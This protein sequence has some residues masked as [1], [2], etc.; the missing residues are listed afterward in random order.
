MLQIVT[1]SL[2]LLDFPI[3]RKSQTCHQLILS[4][5]CQEVEQIL[6][7]IIAWRGDLDGGELFRDRVVLV[8]DETGGIGQ[9]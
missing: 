3:I 6:K 1:T 7:L 5:L 2:G 9:C 4:Q 8:V